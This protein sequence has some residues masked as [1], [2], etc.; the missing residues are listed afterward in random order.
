MVFVAAALGIVPGKGRSQ[1]LASSADTSG[2]AEITTTGTPDRMY[3]PPT[4]GA[5]LTN[6]VFDAYGPYPIAGAAFA[7]GIGQLTNSMPEWNQGAAGYGKRFGSNFGIAV[8]GTTTRFGLAAAF[9]EDTLYYRCEC[10]GV[11]PR[12]RHAVISAFTGRRGE[13]G[14]RV[15]SIPAVVAPYAGAEV[16]VYGWY[17]KRYGAKDAFRMGNYGVLAYIGENVALEFVY[18]GPH[19]L[20]SRMHL[21]N[22][23][24][25]ADQDP[26]DQ[27]PNDQGPNK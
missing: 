2:G 8:V 27:G 18:S 22:P 14:H 7:A 26:N 6:Y 13:D 10:S 12:L 20:F 4:S 21:H 3:I 17:P 16:A 5:K 19:S 11:Y 9:R 15:F 25:S 24:S 1:S 23:R